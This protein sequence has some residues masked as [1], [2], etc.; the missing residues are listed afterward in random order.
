MAADEASKEAA[1][2]AWQYRQWAAKQE[3]EEEEEEEEDKLQ[4]HVMEERRKREAAEEALE[5][6]RARRV[7]AQTLALVAE[8][9]AG[10]AEDEAD[11][12]IALLVRSGRW[13]RGRRGT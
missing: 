4:R 3:E 1:D 5:E 7:A 9:V 12:A 6:E 2:L 13:W 10:A 8:T 11:R